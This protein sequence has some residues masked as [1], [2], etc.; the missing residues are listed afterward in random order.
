MCR[1]GSFPDRS[2]RNRPYQPWSDIL[3]L[4]YAGDSTLHQLQIEAIKR[5][6]YGLNFQLEYSWNR[7][8][9]NTPIVGRSAESLQ[10]RHRS[11]QFRPDSPPYLYGGILL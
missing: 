10:L 11:W 9:D 5:Y 3:Y 8:L 2:N 6:S 1:D 7:S 4:H